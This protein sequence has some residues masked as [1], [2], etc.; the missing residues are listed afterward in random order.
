[1]CEQVTEAFM[2]DL[3]LSLVDAETKMRQVDEE[4][5]SAVM[6]GPWAAVKTT[7]LNLVA[8]GLNVRAWGPGCMGLWIHGMCAWC[9]CI[10]WGYGSMTWVRSVG[11]MGACTRAVGPRLTS[12]PLPPPVS[13]PPF[14][15]PACGLDTTGVHTTQ[16]PGSS[17]RPGS[18]CLQ[19]AAGPV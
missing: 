11:C 12:S 9:G 14:R 2:T 8:R 15:M 16:Q 7:A 5:H 1:M 10:V 17:H 3:H 6:E 13:R 4:G 19:V 18:G